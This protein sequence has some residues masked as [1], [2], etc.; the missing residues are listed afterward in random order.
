MSALAAAD[1]APRTDLGRAGAS[2][3]FESR[4]L[5]T[6][7]GAL[8]YVDEGPRDA[9]P[10]LFLH[11][12]PTWSF[13][14]RRA[15][16]ALRDAHRCIAPDHMGC[17]LSARPR[18]WRYDLAGHAENVLALVESL[19][20]R[21]VT[22]AVHDWG[23]AIGLAF[24][25]RAP[26]RVARLLVTNSAAFP[27]PMPWRIAVCRAPLIGPLLLQR[28]NAFAGLLPYLGVDD[29]ARITP[30]ARHGYALPWRTAADRRAVRRFVE[31]I[32]T[33]PSHRSWRELELADA[34]VDRFADRPVSIVWGERDW[35]FTPQ[36]RDEWIRRLPRARVRS[37]ADVGHLVPEEA[38]ETVEAALRELLAVPIG[39]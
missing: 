29:P 26:D 7:A 2:Y 1:F 17:G 39:S 24:A 28:L 21:N 15:I 13:L 4:Y 18:R 33:R 25:R 37:L 11:G 31:D 12:N 6:P 14:W 34:A 36:F 8:H 10:V 32:P 38:P 30:A 16:R 22:L 20:L 23:G 27:G 9:A 5:H 19:D 35:C 3:P